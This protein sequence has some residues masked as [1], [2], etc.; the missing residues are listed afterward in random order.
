MSSLEKHHFS[1][2]AEREGVILLPQYITNKIFSSLKT[3]VSPNLYFFSCGE[4]LQTSHSANVAIIFV[5]TNTLKK[6]SY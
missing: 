4:F 3:D 2:S 6:K 5:K 1:V